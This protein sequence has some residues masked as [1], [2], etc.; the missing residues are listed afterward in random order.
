MIALCVISGAAMALLSLPEGQFTLAWSHSVE[1][2]R[3]EEDYAVAPE[4]LTVVEA[5]IKG[6]GAGMEPPADAVR[7]PGGWLAYRPS[8]GVLPRVSLA[9][10]IYTADYVI[11]VAGKCRPLGEILPGRVSAG[12]SL[13]PCGGA[14]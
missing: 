2:V 1:K 11:C 13:E 9:A 5:R 3:W 7:R 4:M 10:S 14:R 8:V 6:S 12:V